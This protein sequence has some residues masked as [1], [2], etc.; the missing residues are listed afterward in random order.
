MTLNR[1]AFFAYMASMIGVA[2]AQ[3][4]TCATTGDCVNTITVHTATM[5]TLKPVNGK[6]PVCG[7]MAEKYA[8]K[9][10]LEMYGHDICFAGGGVGEIGSLSVC[11]QPSATKL[12]GPMERTVRCRRCNAAFWQDAEA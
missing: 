11:R 2:K 10:E 8:R 5:E 3:T 6:C 7:T 1:K 4:G 12:I 9:T